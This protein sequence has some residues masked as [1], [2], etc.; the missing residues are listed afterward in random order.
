VLVILKRGEVSKV[1]S[2]DRTTVL[3]FVPLLVLCFPRRIVNVSKSLVLRPLPTS[4][5]T[6]FA[7]YAAISAS[8]I[9]NLFSFKIASVQDSYGRRVSM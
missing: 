7:L 8:M 2:T 1:P 5:L 3:L 4:Q 9:S 6:C